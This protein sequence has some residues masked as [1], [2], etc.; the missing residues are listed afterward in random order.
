VCTP[1]ASGFEIFCA[2]NNAQ[3]FGRFAGML[4]R[5]YDGLRGNGRVA[6]FVL[7]NEVNSNDWFD[8][9]F[10]QGA[11]CNKQ[12]WLQIY[13]D[14]YNWAHDYIAAEQPSA[15]VR[16]PLTHHFGPELDDL[17]DKNPVLSVMTVLR[18][19]APLIAPRPWRVAYHPYAPD[20]LNPQFGAD[21]YP[22][23]TSGNIGV[24]AGFLA[25]EF[26]SVPSARE[27]QLTESGVN[28][29]PPSSEAAQAEAICRSFENVIGTPGIENYVF[30]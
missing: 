21:D 17:T 27:I 9:G 5:R 15:K 24:V 3:D 4:A 18:G 2:P 7:H 1:V 26:P 6:D 28:S 29:L 25:K 14:N 19:L 20:F 8:I 23:A 13:A 10:G 22:R 30:H 11:A 12:A 16:S